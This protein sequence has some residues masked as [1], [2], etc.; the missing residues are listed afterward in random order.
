MSD[1]TL[2]LLNLCLYPFKYTD[3]LIFF[4]PT[5][6]LTIT[7]LFAIVSKLVRGNYK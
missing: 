1:F 4:I 2:S 5:V 3:N 6:S 7:F